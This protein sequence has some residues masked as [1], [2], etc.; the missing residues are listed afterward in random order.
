MPFY[1]RG[2]IAVDLTSEELRQGKEMRKARG[3][4][5]DMTEHEEFEADIRH[6][7][8]IPGSILNSPPIRNYMELFDD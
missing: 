6:K 2:V 3:E 8:N 4:G 7:F 5:W 1:I